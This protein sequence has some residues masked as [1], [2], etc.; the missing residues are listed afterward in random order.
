MSWETKQLVPETQSDEDFIHSYPEYIA[1][2]VECWNQF[3]TE[4]YRNDEQLFGYTTSVIDG[5]LPELFTDDFLSI[6]MD[7]EEQWQAACVRTL[8]KTTEYLN[9]VDNIPNYNTVAEWPNESI[10]YDE[11]FYQITKYR[12]RIETSTGEMRRFKFVEPIQNMDLL[13]AETAPP[14]LNFEDTDNPTLDVYIEEENP[15]DGHVEMPSHVRMQDQTQNSFFESVFPSI[16]LL[17]VY[18]GTFSVGIF[19]VNREKSKEAEN[20]FNLFGMYNVQ[21]DIDRYTNDIYLITYS[22]QKYEDC[23]EFAESVPNVSLEDVYTLLDLPVEGAKQVTKLRENAVEYVHI[24]PGIEYAV[25]GV[26]N[27]EISP[28][29]ARYW[30]YVYYRPEFSVSGVKTSLVDAKELYNSLRDN[31]NMFSQI[32]G[33]SVEPLV[34]EFLEDAE[35]NIGWPE[36][37]STLYLHRL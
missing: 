25:Y 19:E 30:P 23:L 18:T 4:R 34:D 9:P 5:E 16:N 22:Q 24:L 21:L 15:P 27:N 33:D 28:D 3:R 12:F 10:L 17:G 8:Q 35:Q 32:E 6:R 29:L 1:E 11:M 36:M 14:V 37:L 20:V 13:N 7:N 31:K 26:K 2:M